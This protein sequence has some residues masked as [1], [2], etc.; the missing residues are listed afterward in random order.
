[1]S[2]ADCTGKFRRNIHDPTPVILL[3]CLAI[4][5]KHQRRG[6]GENLLRYAI[7]RSVQ[8]AQDIGVR[9]ILVHALHDQ[10]RSFYTHYQFE[11]SPPIRFT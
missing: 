4:D 5:R 7:A 8:V 9:A 1:M 2:N 3:S 10:A 6:F 11:S